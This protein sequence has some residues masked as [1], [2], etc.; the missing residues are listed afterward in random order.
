VSSPNPYIHP[1][2]IVESARIGAGTRIWAF[3]HVLEGASIGDDCNIGDHC[4]VESGAVV[5]DRVTI[6][7]GVAVWDGVVLE[8]GVFVGPAVTFMNDKRPRS[9]RLPEARHVY[10]DDRWLERTLVRRGATLGGGAVVLPGVTIGEFAFVA[11]GAL[12]TRD[13]PP[14]SLVAGHPARVRGW[15]C[16]CGADVELTDDEPTVCGRCG[17][18]LRAAGDG[19]AAVDR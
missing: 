12:V 7:N 14:H 13:V 15:V 18:H 16:S 19:V 1:A 10:A 5:G 3:T 9:P 8:D 17:L 6:K 4:Y 11:A 2:A